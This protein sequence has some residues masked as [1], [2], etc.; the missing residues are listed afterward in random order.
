MNRL[1]NDLKRKNIVYLSL[2]EDVRVLQQGEFKI[3][4]LVNGR[5]MQTLEW[6]M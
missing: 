2:W 1:E 6:L 3:D 5:S 4:R